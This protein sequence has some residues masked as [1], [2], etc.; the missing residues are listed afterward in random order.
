MARPLGIRISACVL[1]TLATLAGM[2]SAN[3][4]TG[5]IVFS[6][7]VVEPTCGASAERVAAWV[8]ATPVPGQSDQNTCGGSNP[9]IAA[10]QMYTVTV[11]HLSDAESDRVLRY[12]S[13]YVRASQVN[14]S[15]PTLI[16]QTYE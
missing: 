6:G 1:I 3:A 15:N 16:T 9:A 12:F 2:P 13:D 4:A 7:A 14:A 8:A 5:R 11:V 10:S